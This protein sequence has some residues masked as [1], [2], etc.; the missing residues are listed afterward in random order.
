MVALGVMPAA[1]QLGAHADYAGFASK[2]SRL[3]VPLVVIGL[4]A[5]SD[6]GKQMPAI[7]LGSLEWV[8]ELAMHAPNSD[9]PNISV[10]GQFTYDV[11]ANYGLERQCTVLGCPTLFINTSAKLGGVIHSNL[12]FPKRVAVAAGNPH[13]PHLQKI[14]SS[15]AKIV[16]E[17]NG[18]YISQSAFEMML[19][20][21]GE[22]NNIPEEDFDRCHKYIHPELSRADFIEWCKRYGNVFFDV[23]SWIE[24]YKHFD[25]VVGTRI[26]GVMLALQAGIPALCIAHDSRIVE[27]CET[28]KVPY[29]FSESISNGF[30]LSELFERYYFDSNIFDSNRH[31]LAKK[32]TQFLIQNKLTSAPWL[33]CIE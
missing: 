16:S 31:I 23:P 15:L 1:N 25:F 5:Q 17:T 24:H 2:I 33:S 28:M 13:L 7:P 27:L 4:G 8:R 18:S 14:E 11:L 10:R 19:L 26:H 3:N 12:R 21:R 30:T 9:F 20:T 32:Y 6:V 29:V 22:F